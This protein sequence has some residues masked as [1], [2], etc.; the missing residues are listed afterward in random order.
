MPIIIMFVNSTKAVAHKI[1]EGWLLT[2]ET[3]TVESNP[4]S[5]PYSMHFMHAKTEGRF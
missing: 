2:R 5:D 1:N 3:K 4:Q